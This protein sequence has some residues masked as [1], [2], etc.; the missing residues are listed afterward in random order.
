MMGAATRQQMLRLRNVWARTAAQHQHSFSTSQRLPAEGE[1]K[2]TTIRQKSQAAIGEMTSVLMGNGK[3]DPHQA[4]GKSV[5]VKARPSV[6]DVKI[7]P[8]GGIRPLGGK[9]R[10][11]GPGQAGRTPGATSAGNARSRRGWRKGKTGEK[12]GEEEDEESMQGQRDSDGMTVEERV[13][14]RRLRFGETALYEPS[15]S[16]PDLEPFMPA[17]PSSAAGRR[18]IVLENLCVLAGG[19][20]VGVAANLGPHVDARAFK[21]NGMR[22]FADLEDRDAAERFLQAQRAAK[23]AREAEK[24][25]AAASTD[26][27]DKQQ[28]QQGQKEAE[29][30][31]ESTT[32]SKGAEADATTE[33]K[34]T[35]TDATT[36]SKGAEIDATTET[37]EAEAEKEGAAEKQVEAA[38]QRPPI[39][40]SAD[41]NVKKAIVDSAIL[42]NYEKPVFATDP[43]GIARSWHLRSGTYGAKDVESF[44][45]KLLSLLGPETKGSGSR[46][47]AG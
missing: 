21:A 46:P 24:A 34:G 29:A 25:A 30:T 8:K 23:E 27:K 26:P 37:K 16:M 31:T 19:N 1:E 6:I 10:F 4:P 12:K 18:A 42:G 47:T 36:E 3:H 43:V 35:E 17:E 32:E 38:P 15:L 20:S 7:L 39:M 14:D 33:S 41:E 2:P 40:Q 28:Q 9:G 22:Y 5:G 44:E 11:A 45:R 13:L